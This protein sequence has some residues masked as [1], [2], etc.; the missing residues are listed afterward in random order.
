MKRRIGT[1]VLA[2]LGMLILILDAKSALSGAAEGITLC[3]QVVIPSL[4]PF[5]VLSM[6]LTSSLSGTSLSLLRPIGRLCGIP[7]GSESLLLTGFLGGYPVGAQNTAQSYRDGQLSRSSAER[8]LG[9]CNNAGP[10]FLFGIV[11]QKFSQWWIPWLLWGI[12]ILSALIAALLLPGRDHSAVLIKKTQPLSAQSAL[13]RS[14][15]VMAE[16]C[17][18]IILMRVVI[19]F[20]DRWFLWLLSAQWQVVIMGLLELSNGCCELELIECTGLRFIAA[21]GMISLGG[22]CVAMQT[23]SAAAPLKLRSYFSGKMIQTVCSICLAFIAQKMLLPLEEQL[24]IP[25][26]FAAVAPVVLAFFAVI[27]RESEKNSSI[28]QMIGV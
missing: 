15:R 7:K 18:W 19:A 14:L 10:A 12:H 25:S 23:A 28:P 8:M 9:F 16:V 6:L 24:T 21:A 27:C 2:A 20:I 1:A 17:G 11:A 5:F 22:L 26:V 4:L 3:I 13:K